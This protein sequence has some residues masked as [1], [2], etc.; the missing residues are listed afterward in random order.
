MSAKERNDEH[1]VPDDEEFVQYKHYVFT[2]T[3]LHS[4]SLSAIEALE[5][6]EPKVTVFE[7]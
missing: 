7:R 6:K 2:A 4:L 3:Q 5:Y 1:L